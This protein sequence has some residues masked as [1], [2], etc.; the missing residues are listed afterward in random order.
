MERL[1]RELVGCNRIVIKLRFL[2]FILV[3]S[4]RFET[5]HDGRGET[6]GGVE[7]KERERE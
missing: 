6:L 4:M 1:I 3:L 7:M 2:R 5:R